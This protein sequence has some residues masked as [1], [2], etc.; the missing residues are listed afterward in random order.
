LPK[1]DS[2]ASECED[3]I[4]VNLDSLRFAVS[5]GATEGFN[6]RRWARYLTTAWT[7]APPIELDLTLLHSQVKTLGHR[8][9]EQKDTAGLP[10]Y[11]EEK[12]SQGAFAAFVGLHIHSSGTWEAVAIGDCCLIHENADYFYAFPLTT[13]AEFNSRPMLIPSLIDKYPSLGGAVRI[14]EGTSQAGD[15][16]LLMSDAIACWYLGLGRSSPD[17]L[18]RFRSALDAPDKAALADLVA[19]ERAEQH[20]RN[21]DVAVL[22]L[23]VLSV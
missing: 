23:R 6:S 13:P 15:R 4:G 19:D 2:R 1:R 22:N 20:L 18:S 10:W 12:A 21:D 11:L 5:D 16:F 7:S 17:V 14:S 3:A 8:L 9:F